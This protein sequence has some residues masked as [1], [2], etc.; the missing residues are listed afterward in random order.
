MMVVTVAALISAVIAGAFMFIFDHVSDTMLF[1]WITDDD[2]Q[3]MFAPKPLQALLH[4][5][6]TAK[7]HLVLEEQQEYGRRR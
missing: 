4:E 2:G 3:T 7:R 5:Y 6:R 1:C